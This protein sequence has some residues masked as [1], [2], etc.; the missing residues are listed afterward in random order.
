MSHHTKESKTW[1]ALFPVA[2]VEVASVSLPAEVTAAY[3]EVGELFCQSR[4]VRE[5]EI[6]MSLKL[7][8]LK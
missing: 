3:M 2:R 6:S 1:V 8:F 5:V 4:G 7:C